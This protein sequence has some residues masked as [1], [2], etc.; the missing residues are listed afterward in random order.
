MGLHVFYAV[1]LHSRIGR[2][3]GYPNIRALEE[4]QTGTACRGEEHDVTIVWSI[5]SGKR[6]VSMDGREVHFST[7]RSGILEFSWSTRGNHVIKILAH[8]A[9]P[10][11]ATP[12]FR[13]YDLWIDGQSFFTMPKVYELGLKGPPGARARIP[14]RF[15]YPAADVGRPQSGRMYDLDRGA[16]VEPRTREQEEADLQRAI[17]ESIE[18]SRRYL[19]RP[20]SQGQIEGQPAPV[21]APAPT[22]ESNLLDFGSDPAPAPPAPNSYYEAQS[23]TSNSS[24]PAVSAAPTYQTAPPAYGGYG[25]PPSSTPYLALPAPPGVMSPVGS[26]A[27]GPIYAPNASPYAPAPAYGSPPP[28]QSSG[29]Y[30]GGPPPPQYGAPAPSYS[31]TESYAPPPAEDSFAPQYQQQPLPPA[32]DPFAP[33]PPPPPTATDINRSVRNIVAASSLNVTPVLIFI[34]F[35]PLEMQLHPF[36]KFRF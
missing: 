28:A 29:Y 9:P 36:L 17:N 32:D 7:N 33:K 35:S 18:E 14:G 15:D 31:Y 4:G 21:P 25:G 30:N 3:F 27:P 8:A 22:F 1:R 5:T 12:G 19:E 24:F 11:S 13:Q 2:R 26:T 34:L 20:K 10:L 16:Y 6:E 23:V